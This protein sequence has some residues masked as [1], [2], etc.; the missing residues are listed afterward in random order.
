MQWEQARLAAESADRGLVLA[1]DE[2]QK[3]PNWSETV[4]GLWDADRRLDRPLHVIL[5]GSAPLLMQQGMSESFAGRYE[6]VRLMHWSFAE[7][8]AAFG[9]DLQR[10]VYFGV[11]REAPRSF[12]SR[13][14]GALT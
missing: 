2:I 14:D 8:S 7:M 12:P 9:F 1:I 3:I 13:A 5:L 11:I 4:K 10:Y 6:T